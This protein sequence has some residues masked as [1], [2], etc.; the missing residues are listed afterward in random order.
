[1]KPGGKLGQGCGGTSLEEGER[2]RRKV[3]KDGKIN[4]LAPG[5]CWE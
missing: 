4:R 1:M 3:A 2:G 5:H